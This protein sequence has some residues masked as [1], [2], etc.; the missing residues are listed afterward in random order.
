MNA[1]VITI[2]PSPCYYRGRK[3]RP[4][5]G[6]CVPLVRAAPWTS[7]VPALSSAPKGAT[8]KKP[9]QGL[10]VGE[11]GWRVWW[12]KVGDS[13]CLPIGICHHV[14]EGAEEGQAGLICVPD[15]LVHGGG[16]CK[17]SPITCLLPPLLLTENT[18]TPAFL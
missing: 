5:G 3:P 7:H 9:C 1:S 12:G 16:S 2:T 11:A 15:P 18:G 4:S 8:L 10:P 17:P 6:V 13:G 14:Q